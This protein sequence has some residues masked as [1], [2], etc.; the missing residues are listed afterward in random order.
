[1]NSF[2]VSEEEDLLPTYYF[3]SNATYEEN[4]FRLDPSLREKWVRVLFPNFF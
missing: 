3:S 4:L 2:R 1:M